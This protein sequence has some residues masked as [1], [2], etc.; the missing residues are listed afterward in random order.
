MAGLRGAIHQVPSSVSAIKIAGQRAHALVRAG[1]QVSL[2]ARP[3]KVARFE[4]TGLHR[5]D[6]MVDL[7]V[8]SLVL[9]SRL[10]RGFEELLV[11]G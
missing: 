1:E 10:S 3:V 6:A 4:A 9:P 5:M 2:A 8:L 7:D 11:R